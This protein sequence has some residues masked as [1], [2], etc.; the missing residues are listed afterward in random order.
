[1]SR[2]LEPL[3]DVAGTAAGV[4]GMMTLT[5]A[6]LLAAIVGMRIGT[7]TTPWAVGYLCYGTIALGLLIAAGRTPE[8]VPDV[9]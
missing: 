9:A 4:L 6:S 5:G 7:S 1:M 2:A 8:P 3:G